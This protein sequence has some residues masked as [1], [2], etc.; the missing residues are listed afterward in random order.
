MEPL[1]ALAVV[2]AVLLLP[3]SLASTVIM[4]IYAF[5]RWD[6]TGLR[7]A[8]VS[9]LGGLLGSTFLVLHILIRGNAA[10]DDGALLHFAVLVAITVPAAY[11]LVL[12]LRL[13]TDPI[14]EA[15]AAE[16]AW[17]E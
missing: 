1:V 4:G 13:R 5:R 2:A 9:R 16:G 8:F 12:F 10:T 7:H 3:I 11:W 17:R 15:E 6:L 14:T